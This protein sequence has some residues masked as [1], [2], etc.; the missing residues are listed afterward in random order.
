[1]SF[2]VNENQNRI[3]LSV[4]EVTSVLKKNIEETFPNVWIRGELSN[5]KTYASGH[6][7]FTL[8]DEETQISGALFRG[9]KKYLKFEPEDGMSVI[10]HGKITVF[11]QRGQYQLIVDY[12]EP[13]GIGA[14]QLAFEQLKEKLNKEGLFDAKHKKKLPFLP[15]T[16]GVV[17]SLH[18]AAVHDICTVL[19]RRFPKIEI[20][21]YPVKVQGEGAAEEI[22]SAIDYFSQNQNADALIVGRGGGSLEDLWA[23][24]EEIVARSIAECT[25]PVISAVGHETDFTICDFVADIRAATPSAAAEIC[26]PEY[27]ALEEKLSQSRKSLILSWVKYFRENQQQIELFKRR[28]PSPKTMWEMAQFKLGDL[29]N[30]LYQAIHIQIRDYML[31]VHELKTML[32]SPDILL[33]NQKHKLKTVQTRLVDLMLQTLKDFNFNLKNQFTK[34]NLLS[35]KEVLKRG[36]V[37]AKGS[38]GRVLTRKKLTEKEKSMSLVFYDGEVEVYT[39]ERN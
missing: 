33:L 10:I 35:P 3:V 7:Y 36:Y 27:K 9:Y 34:I 32:K 30:R 19:K 22:S 21:I 1:M 14:L 39:K 12:I 37:I 18:G 17:T 25:I 15:K 5:Y 26:V 20:L 11:E 28:I 38:D 13:D 16:I 29:E 24:N 31:A 8:K 6:S 23:F 4:S 2:A